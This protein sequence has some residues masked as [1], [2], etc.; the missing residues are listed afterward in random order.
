MHVQF[1]LYIYVGCPSNEELLWKLKLEQFPNVQIH[2]E[3]NTSSASTFLSFSHCYCC[4]CSKDKSKNRFQNQQYYLKTYCTGKK[5]YIFV[6]WLPY[7]CLVKEVKLKLYMHCMMIIC[8]NLTKQKKL[9]EEN[10][11]N[12]RKCWIRNRMY[13]T[14]A[15]MCML[16][17]RMRWKFCDGRP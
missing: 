17:Y 13:S 15:R 4:C 6:R 11:L 5:M 12:V 2:F 8:I 3:C 14:Y 10:W 16:L 7:D 9:T 1:Y